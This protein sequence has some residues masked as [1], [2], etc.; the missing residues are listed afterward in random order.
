MTAPA[1]HPPRA[2]ATPPSP[3]KL[4]HGPLLFIDL[5]T[6][7]AN[8]A[9]DRIIEIG[10][11]EVDAQGAREWSALVDPE[12]PVPEFITGL[13]GIDSAMVDG[14]PTFAQL[15]PLL[16]EKLRGRLFIAHNARFDYGFLKREFLRLGIEFRAPQL[17]TVKLSRKLFP[18][19]HR[20]SLD[21]LIARFNI[22]VAHRHR[23]LAD[24]QVLWQLWQQ[25]HATLP[26]ETLQHTVE[27]L[28]GRPQLPPQLAPDTLDDVPEAP[29]AYAFYDADG[30]ALLIKRASNL[31]T[32]MMG[33]FAPARRDTAIVRSVCRVAWREAAGEFGARLAEQAFA[34]ALNPL[35]DELCAWQCLAR[36]ADEPTG[37]GRSD[38]RGHFRPELVFAGT[39]DLATAPEL[40][41]LYPNAREARKSLRK[42]VEANGLCHTLTG[43]GNG[44]PGEP[45][46]G[47]RQKTCRGAC[48]G[49]EAV[50]LHD[51][52]LLAALAKQRIERWPFAGPVALVERD[53]WGMR[54]D[55][56]LFD[57]WRHLGTAHD[58]ARLSEM[59]EIREERPF[60]PEIYRIAQRFMKLGKVRVVPLSAGGA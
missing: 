43:L 56:H 7:G 3:A 35:S 5:E 47:F 60:D 15:A 40:F 6:T 30:Q 20:H 17:C 22:E 38:T 50:G 16:Q 53:E 9:V 28:I 32:Q 41:G 10:L 54:E 31:R 12:R 21:T 49:K 29:G 18:E 2:D 48:A 25:W 36:E 14:A 4:S 27:T 58:E 39:T 44:R 34:V 59:L 57:R 8:L 45:C 51:A 24:A 46:V 13:T 1:S 19:H 23:A 42:L 55:F 11:V 37:M 33:Q 52:R 26:A